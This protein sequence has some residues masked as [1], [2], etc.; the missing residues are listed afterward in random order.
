LVCRCLFFDNGYAN[1]YK[2]F[3]SCAVRLTNSVLVRP[4]P[5]SYIGGMPPGGVKIPQNG[6]ASQTLN[7]YRVIM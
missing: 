2:K 1:F 3:D 6:Q 7:A 4:S 5:P